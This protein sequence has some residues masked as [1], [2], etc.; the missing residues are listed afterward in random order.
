[1]PDKK[2]DLAILGGGPG[3]YTAA[4]RASQ[5]GMSVALAENKYMGGTCLNVGC[6][7]SKALIHST[8]VYSEAMGGK[9]YGI[10][11]SD[12][13]ADWTAIQKY[14][15]RCVIKLRKGVEGLMRKNNIEIFNGHGRMSG[16]DSIDVDGTVI[17]AEHIVIAVGSRAVSLPPLPIDGDKIITSIHAL[18]LDELP[19]SILIVGAG[20]I[21]CE[22]AYIMST[23]GVDVTMVEFFDHALPMED[24]EISIQYE[25]I[26][27]RRKITLHTQ[28]SVERV[29]INGSGV[30]ASVKP[31]DGGDVFTVETD[32]VLVS[33]GRGPATM[34]CGFEEIGIPMEKGFIRVDEFN[35]TGVGNVRAIGDAVGGLMLAHK[36]MT[37]GI[38]VVE[39]IAGI[40][41]KPLVMENIPRATYSKPEVGSVGLMETEARERF[42]DSV[43]VGR[44]PFSACPK[45]VI[46]GEGYGFV[47]LIA[48]G[49]DGKLV[50][51][52]AIGVFATDLISTAATAI[53]LG[54]TAEEFAR[55]VQAHPSLGEIWNEAA[56]GLLDGPINL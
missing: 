26:V 18:N 2:F 43:K 36:A 16:A 56:Y 4:I 10:T 1:M 30:S 54:T 6:I 8:S 50:G 37:E 3:G 41:R 40:D 20:A 24:E 52:H 33:V 23:M 17:S 19:E 55:V 44:F 35:R 22:F 48:A 27:R 34:D 5:L 46:I 31:R 28:C 38:F 15:H 51:A 32:K 42:G 7:P 12:I 45:A 53:S 39:S 47:K 29:E 14:K 21:G 9:T 11:S 13:S 25:E 49:D